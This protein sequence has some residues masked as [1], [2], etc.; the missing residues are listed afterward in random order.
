MRGNRKPRIVPHA[1]RGLRGLQQTED[2]GDMTDRDRDAEHIGVHGDVWVEHHI[3]IG[4]VK[5]HVLAHGVQFVHPAIARLA[6]GCGQLDTRHFHHAT[7]G[8]C[9]CRR[10]A[11]GHG[12][13]GIEGIVG[14]RQVV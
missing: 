9:V 13:I 12:R 10:I 3:G 1:G 14:R 6:V 4:F 2:A 5:R 7:G 11:A 8:P